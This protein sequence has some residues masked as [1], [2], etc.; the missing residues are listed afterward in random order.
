VASVL[1]PAFSDTHVTYTT[2]NRM[3]PKP[4]F[5][6]AVG[7][8]DQEIRKAAPGFD[9]YEK[10]FALVPRY[11]AGD[12]MWEK[13]PL[14]YA[15]TSG[16]V[17]QRDYHSLWLDPAK[18]DLNAIRNHGVAFGVETNVGTFWG[19]GYAQNVQMHEIH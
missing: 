5:V 8:R 13:M 11:Y 4:E 19:Q 2:N 1:T 18:V 15:G 17:E 7:I 6:M 14:K 3:A 12:I 16:I 10:A 9:G